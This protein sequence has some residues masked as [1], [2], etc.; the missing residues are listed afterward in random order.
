M[1]S[2]FRRAAFRLRQSRDQT[3]VTRL[4]L[5][6]EGR[7]GFQGKTIMKAERL[8]VCEASVRVAADAFVYLLKVELL[9]DIPE[10]DSFS[11]GR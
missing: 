7:S 4:S 8:H 3:E 2:I 6:V 1:M 11:E 10:P 5:T 9:C